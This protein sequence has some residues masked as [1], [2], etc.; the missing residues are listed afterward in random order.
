MV[1]VHVTVA[2]MTENAIAVVGLVVSPVNVLL[3]ETAIDVEQQIIWF[4]IAQMTKLN[5]T[6]V[7][8][9]DTLLETVLYIIK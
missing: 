3:V 5:A 4:E 7:T 1:T 2:L 6:I 8:K 9:W